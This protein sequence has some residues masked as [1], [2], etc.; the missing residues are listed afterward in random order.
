VRCYRKTIFEKKTI[1]KQNSLGTQSREPRF[2][3]N[4]LMPNKGI[5]L[6]LLPTVHQSRLTHIPLNQ[7]EPELARLASCPCSDG[8]LHVVGSSELVI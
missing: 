1:A 8:G 3:A 5:I 4:N 6:S 2:E 7:T